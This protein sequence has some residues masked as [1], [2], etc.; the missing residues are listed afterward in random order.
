ML[1]DAMFDLPDGR[2]INPLHK[3]PWLGQTLPADTPPLLAHLQGEWPCVPFG[4]PPDTPLTGA[5]EGLHPKPVRWPHGYG[6]NHAWTLSQRT[7]DNV[8]A[9]IDYPDGGPVTSL[10]RHVSGRPGAAVLDIT[11]EIAVGRAAQVPVGLHPVFRLPET[12]GGARL[13]LGRHG[14]IWSYPSDT[15]GA[16]AFAYRDPVATFDA[17]TDGIFG[18]LSLPYPMASETLLLLD[19]SEG[20][21]SL[22]NNIEGYRAI[23]E[24]DAT[25]LPSLMLWISNKGRQASPWNGKHLALGIEPV[26]A[27]FD[28]GEAITGSTSPLAKAGV[29]TAVSIQPDR[30]WRTSYAIGLEAND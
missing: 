29:R 15:G 7:A 20:H 13:G 25:A 14:R 4:A 24:W 8:T 27:P 16:R 22:E 26:C 19:S 21:V 23:L 6:A 9:R 2:Q 30:P 17:L 11:L 28:L 5:W 3:A 1:T 12:V 18:P 10:T